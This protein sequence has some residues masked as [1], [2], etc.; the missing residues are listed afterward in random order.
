MAG[1]G[2]NA[3][4]RRPE[5][6][7]AFEPPAV[8]LRVEVSGQM[9]AEGEAVGG[10]PVVGEGEGR[11]EIGRAVF[12]CAVDAGLEGIALAAAE[13]LRQALIGAA[14]GKRHAQH[15]VGRQAIIEAAREAD[16]A[17]G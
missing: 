13:P 11:G 16:R 5:P 7:A 6:I 3:A 15:R 17:R 12:R 2:R 9:V 4:V 8:A 14:T 1:V 10:H